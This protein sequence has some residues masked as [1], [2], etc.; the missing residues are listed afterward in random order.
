MVL[1]DAL[2][3][4]SAED[5]LLEVRKDID[6]LPEDSEILQIK[7]DIMSLKSELNELRDINV[8]DSNP[9][10]RIRELPEITSIIPAVSSR[11]TGKKYPSGFSTTAYHNQIAGGLEVLIDKQKTY[12]YSQLEDEC[13][14]LAAMFRKY[15]RRLK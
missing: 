11:Y 9:E 8:F 12:E 4:Y 5:A 10:Y 3:D 14:R 1:M 6:R 2:S 15:D 13:L 7:S